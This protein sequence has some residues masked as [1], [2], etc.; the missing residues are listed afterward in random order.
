M[1]ANFRVRLLA[2]FEA[3]DDFG[4]LL[5]WL[6][7]DKTKV[8]D[9]GELKDWEIFTG[10]LPVTAIQDIDPKKDAK[11]DPKGKKKNENVLE[12]GKTY[13]GFFELADD[14]VRVDEVQDL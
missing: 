6:A 13:S 1:V 9:C 5:E 10:D 12:Q 3:Q 4:I 7:N 8:V 2:D 11:K 14:D